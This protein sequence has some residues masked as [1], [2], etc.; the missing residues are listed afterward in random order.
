MRLQRDDPTRLAL[1]CQYL[2]ELPG[3]DC[4]GVCQK[5]THPSYCAF[6][7]DGVVLCIEHLRATDFTVS[8]FPVLH[9]ASCLCGNV[10][11]VGEVC[12]CFKM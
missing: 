12:L 2:P 10:R 8:S 11:E 5:A 7:D 9:P 1:R 3:P 4:P 6:R